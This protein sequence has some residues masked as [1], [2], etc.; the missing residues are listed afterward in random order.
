[1]GFECAVSVCYYDVKLCVCC[2][3]EL[4]GFLCWGL[5]CILVVCYVSIYVFM[6][7]GDLCAG[8]RVLTCSAVVCPCGR[9]Q[10]PCT[11]VMVVALC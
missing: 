1:M 10:W 7:D 4:G 8:F 11:D 9:G 3:W 2:I 6:C 5:V